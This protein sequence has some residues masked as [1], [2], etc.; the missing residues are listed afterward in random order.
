[1]LRTPLNGLPHKDKILILKNYNGKTAETIASENGFVEL[2]NYLRDK[3]R[4]MYGSKL[5]KNIFP[6]TNNC[7]HNNNYNTTYN[8][9]AKN[10]NNNFCII[11]IENC[12]QKYK[13]MKSFRK[14]G[15]NDEKEIEENMLNCN[16]MTRIIGEQDS[17]EKNEKIEITDIEKIL[18]R[19]INFEAIED[20]NSKNKY[21]NFNFSSLKKNHKK[22]IVDGRE[23]KKKEVVSSARQNNT[24]IKESKCMKKEEEGRE[25]GREEEVF[26]DEADN[27]EYSFALAPQAR[28]AVGYY[29]IQNDNNDDD[30]DGNN[31]NNNHNNILTNTG[32]TTNNNDNIECDNNNNNNNN[33]NN[34]IDKNDNK[35]NDDNNND[36]SNSSFIDKNEYIII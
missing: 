17:E 30:N 34:G 5:Y 8:E 15:N 6:N 18:F 36:M 21:T 24:Y 20:E 27:E 29:S 13:K 32:T 16:K 14:V 2:S 7:D 25:E 28:S 35:N 22:E 33:S 4:E 9:K 3:G 11:P 23:K 10:E 12:D 31:D 26:D 19:K 1:M